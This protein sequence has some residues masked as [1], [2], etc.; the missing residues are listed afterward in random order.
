MTY[1]D[2]EKFTSEMHDP[3]TRYP[4]PERENNTETPSRGTGVEPAKHPLKIK[5]EMFLQL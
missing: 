3:H 2:V 1:D 4:L 5:S